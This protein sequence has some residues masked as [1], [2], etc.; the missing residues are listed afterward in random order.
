[1][2]Y[3]VFPLHPETPD[4]GTA[5]DDLFAGQ[6]DVAAMM[7]RLHQVAGELNLP[8]SDRTHT[9][10]SRRA[11]ELGKWA[12]QQ[13]LGE[14]FQDA[15]YRAYFVDGQ[16]IAQTDVLTAIA[17]T[18]GLEVAAAEKAL[19]DGDFSATVD[20]DWQRARDMEV[21]AV[22][23]TLYANKRLVGFSPYEAFREMVTA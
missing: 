14:E 3:T 5:L 10:N 2:R 23:T 1:V 8:F 7:A 18:I 9:Y 15:V 4:T 16:N 19:L 17:A 22:P 21:T 6:F 20:D 11:Q 12:E 13:G